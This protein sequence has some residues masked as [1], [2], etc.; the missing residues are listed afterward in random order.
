M[1]AV[2][3]QPLALQLLVQHWGE[4]NST[5]KKEILETYHGADHICTIIFL[6]F[7]KTFEAILVFLQTEFSH[8]QTV[9][10]KGRMAFH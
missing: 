7:R 5:V 6:L 3:K 9:I 4:V 8:G 1:E 10:G 2:L